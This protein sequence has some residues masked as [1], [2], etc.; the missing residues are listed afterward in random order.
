[1]ALDRIDRAELD[2]AHTVVV[3]TGNAHKLVE[4][5]TML[6]AA[7]PGM[8]FVALGQLGDFEDPEETGTTF[9]ENAVIKARAAV[10]GTG[11]A[12]VA[13]DSG[14]MVDALDGAPG[15]YSAR[16]AGVHGD[17]EANNAK[18]LAA[19]EGVAAPARTAR[20]VSSIVF[21]E[22]DGAVTMG[23]GTCEGTVGTVGRG[24]HGFGYDPL[25]LPDDTP[26][27]TM[28][29]LEPDEKNAIS[30]R[31]HALQDLCA[32]LAERGERA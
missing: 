28:A 9:A 13:D 21:I 14:L 22:P 18:L 15:V 24:E 30:H 3:A 19:L 16:Y 11:L 17:D 2:P 25:F 32:K 6:S 5:E 10:D 20:F 4:I 26:G 29:E 7:L 23:E 1:M 31:F 27:R 12:A 8:R